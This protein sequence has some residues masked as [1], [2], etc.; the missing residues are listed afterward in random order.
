VHKLSG[1]LLTLQD[2]DRRWLARELHD[3]TAQLLVGLGINLSVV[4]ESAAPLGPRAEQA[5]A[6]SRGLADRCLRE[7][8]TVSYLVYP[9]ELDGLGLQCA[10]V[11]YLD[12]F[13]QRSGVQVDPRP[14]IRLKNPKGL[15]HSIAGD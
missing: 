4:N 13:S 11:S 6:E 10:L 7:I 8:R 3:S 1:R 5:L 2:E 12:G 15:T 14:P 9:P